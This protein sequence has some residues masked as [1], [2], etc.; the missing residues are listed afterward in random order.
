MIDFLAGRLYN[1][2]PGQ[3][4]N[5]IADIEFPPQEVRLVHD[6]VPCPPPCPSRLA[7]TLG[8]LSLLGSIVGCGADSA[9]QTRSKVQWTPIAGTN[10]AVLDES[11]DLRDEFVFGLRIM[12]AKGIDSA[13]LGVDVRPAVVRLRKNARL[14]SIDIVSA[15]NMRDVRLSFPLSSGNEID[16]GAAVPFEL[17]SPA[18][19]KDVNAFVGGRAP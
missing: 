6:F 8:A 13:V 14:G 1:D 18:F 2:T 15:T 10:R 17:N 3:P 11:R 16:F 7:R 9:N 19:L 5:A 12:Q 4:I